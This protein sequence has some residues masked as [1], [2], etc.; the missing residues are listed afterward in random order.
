MQHNGVCTDTTIVNE[1]IVYSDTEGNI[2]SF[3][4]PTIEIGCSNIIIEPCPEPI[5]VSIDDC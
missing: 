3:P 5:D 2:A 1:S 4:N